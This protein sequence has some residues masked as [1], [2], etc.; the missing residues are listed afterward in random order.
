MKNRPGKALALRS[1]EKTPTPILP[2][3]DRDCK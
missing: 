2:K 3:E 1:R